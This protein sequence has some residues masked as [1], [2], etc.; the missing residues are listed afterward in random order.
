MLRAITPQS[1]C[2]KLDVFPVK[3]TQEAISVDVGSASVTA[4]SPA[5]KGG[6]DTSIDANNVFGVESRP[7]Y[8]AQ[9]PI[10]ETHCIARNQSTHMEQNPW[11]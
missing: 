2:R 11:R 8:E 4:S 6:S 1:T 5:G 7:Y 10:S 9:D 3:V